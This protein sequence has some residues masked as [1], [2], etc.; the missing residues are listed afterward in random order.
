MAQKE[1]GTSQ[2]KKNASMHLTKDLQ[3]NY[4]RKFQ[5]QE[6]DREEIKE[7]LKDLTKQKSPKQ[8]LEEALEALDNASFYFAVATEGLRKHFS[9]YLQWQEQKKT[10]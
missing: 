7:K 9:D 2:Q 8:I 1:N 6:K 4:K 3:L 5:M 10:G